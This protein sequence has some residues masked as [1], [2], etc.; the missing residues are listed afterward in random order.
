[1]KIVRRFDSALVE[2]FGPH[3]AKLRDIFADEEEQ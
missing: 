2:R 3:Y 1:M